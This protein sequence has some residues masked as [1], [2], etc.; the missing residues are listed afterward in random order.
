MP[1]WGLL[2]LL[3][4]LKTAESPLKSYL[5]AVTAY[6]IVNIVLTRNYNVLM[7]FSK[8]PNWIYPV[9]FV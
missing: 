4:I 1:L 7:D 8:A 2:N 5:E 6:I 9:E 3:Y